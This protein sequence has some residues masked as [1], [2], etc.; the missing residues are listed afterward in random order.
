MVHSNIV[1][2]KKE[3]NI[4]IRKQ[5][6]TFFFFLKFNTNVVHLEK[7]ANSILQPIMA[8]YLTHF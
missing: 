1:H 6:I 7:N 4:A 3:N 8:V 5:E 2:F